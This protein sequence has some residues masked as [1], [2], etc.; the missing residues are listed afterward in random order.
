MTTITGTDAPALPPDWMATK[1]FQM[2]IHYEFGRKGLWSGPS[3][4][5]IDD[6]L[7]PV[8]GQVGYVQVTQVPSIISCTKCRKAFA[9]QE[10]R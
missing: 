8:C 7:T 4:K 5:D 9:R 10:E 1:P 6:R 3:R 2:T